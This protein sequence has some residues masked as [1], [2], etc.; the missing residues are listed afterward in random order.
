[1]ISEPIKLCFLP[2]TDTV[3]N[4]CIIIIVLPLNCSEVNRKALVKGP[5]VAQIKNILQLYRCR[6]K[7]LTLLFLMMRSDTIKEAGSVWKLSLPVLFWGKFSDSQWLLRILNENDLCMYIAVYDDVCY[8]FSFFIVVK[9]TCK[10]KIFVS[11]KQG[12]YYSKLN[13]MNLQ[14]SWILKQKLSGYWYL[15]TVA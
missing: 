14:C 13:L 1:M 11:R 2:S 4:T 10:P 15:A 7:L 3:Q 5:T 9:Y 8:I 6:L 12:K